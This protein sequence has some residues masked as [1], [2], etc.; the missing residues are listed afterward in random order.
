[1]PSAH[2]SAFSISATTTLK[3]IFSPPTS[4]EH[5]FQVT[6]QSR[7]KNKNQNPSTAAPTAVTPALHIY[8]L[9][10][11]WTFS[12]VRYQVLQ[13]KRPG[14][15]SAIL[16]CTYSVSTN[17]EALRCALG[18]RHFNPSDPE[19]LPQTH[20]CHYLPYNSTFFW[21]PHIR[22]AAQSSPLS[23]YLLTYSALVIR[24]WIANSAC[25][26]FS[27]FCLLP[28]TNTFCL[29]GQF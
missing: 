1:M 5:T 13:P 8:A 7:T 26:H 25:Y 23:P 16:T 2:H 18:A 28:A 19:L 22:R 6:T 15:S 14:P 12:P 11:N 24:S 27:L 21:L 4:T 3:S 10:D 9:Q 17:L 29:S 20:D